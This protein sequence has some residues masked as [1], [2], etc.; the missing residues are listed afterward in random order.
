MSKRRTRCRAT[1]AVVVTVTFL[2]AS[3]VAVPA[4]KQTDTAALAMLWYQQPATQWDH[5]MPIGNGRLGGMVA[6]GGV[7][8]DLT[9]SGGLASSA[10][11]R[12]GV[13]AA[14]RIRAPRGQAIAAITAG[15]KAVGFR[16]EGAVAVLDASAGGVYE[17]GFR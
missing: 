12:T 6:R 1:A 8:I 3:E 17:V 7:E 4:L 10:V 5:A 14:H 16:S 13:A 15:G 9:W 11:L 2:T